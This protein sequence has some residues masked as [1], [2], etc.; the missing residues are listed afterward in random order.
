MLSQYL[1]NYSD[2]LEGAKESIFIPKF[3]DPTIKLSKTKM[4]VIKGLFPLF[5]LI[6]AM[7]LVAQAWEGD[8]SYGGGE[9]IAPMCATHTELHVHTLH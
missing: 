8:R 4:L 3:I 1:Y 5:M 2:L 7:C 9:Y 6:G